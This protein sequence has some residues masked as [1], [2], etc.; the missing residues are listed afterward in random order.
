[1]ITATYEEWEDHKDAKIPMYIF[2]KTFNN[3][4]EMYQ[5]E[6]EQS[7]HLSLIIVRKKAI[8]ENGRNIL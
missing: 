3:I 5:Y 1:M 6:L 2:Y 8:D 7:G 4:N